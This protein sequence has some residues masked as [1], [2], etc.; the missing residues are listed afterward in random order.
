VTTPS[1]RPND[2]DLPPVIVVGGPTASGKSALAVELAE[3]LSGVVINADAMQ[4]Y[5]ELPILTAQPSASDLK[6]VP[7]RLFGVLA[8]DDP[9][10]VGRWRE[11]A[12]A[13]IT[14]ARDSGMP[15]IVVGGTGFYL[16][17]LTQGIDE[18]PPVPVDLRAEIE[19]R[20]DTQGGEAFR[21]GLA[22]HDPVLA[23]RLAPAD[24]QRLVR[25]AS[26][27]EAT[28]RP[29]SDWQSGEGGTTNSG[30]QAHMFVMMPP[31]EALYAACDARFAA[32]VAGGALEEVSEFRTR[33]IDPR[34]PLTKAVGLR[35]LGRHIDGD[36]TLE[37]A[38]EEGRRATRRYAKRQYT[39]FRHQSGTADVI[40][41]QYSESLSVQIF[42]KVRLF[43]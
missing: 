16:R 29:L 9:G 13:A 2:D 11:L 42:N 22:R 31:R 24:R 34:L 37:D 40:V 36:I 39:W 3:G 43:S 8:A 1:G 23:A 5:R 28:G 6:R 18:I 33:G 17:A 38:I 21:A 15:A 41:E 19:A 12:L 14:E 27:L 30:L 32:M 7:H 10:S 26:V 4:L 20:Y 35:E 25:A